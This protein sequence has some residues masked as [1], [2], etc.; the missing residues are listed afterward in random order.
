MI[1]F[2]SFAPVVL[3]LSLGSCTALWDRLPGEANFVDWNQSEDWGGEEL[4]EVQLGLKAGQLEVR[5]GTSSELYNLKIHY[6]ELA[7]EPQ[8]ELQRQGNRAELFIGMEGKGK[9]LRGLGDSRLNLCLNPDVP[10]EL[11]AR[12]G[13]GGSNIDLSGMK[14]HS[15]VLQSGVGETKVGISEPNRARCKE[16]ELLSGVGAFEVVGLGHLA[17]DELEFHGGIGKA[18]LDF[19]G[20]CSQLGEITIRVGIGDV[21]IRLPRSIGAEVRGSEGF[22]SEFNMPGFRRC[23]DAYHSENSDHAA[24]IVRFQIQAGI[25]RI[26][27][28]WI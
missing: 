5:P 6:N 16:V 20:S 28:E 13:V 14:I 1:M 9:S 3:V 23:G 2:S 11:H 18:K 8:V 12:T 25:G 24:E 7:F 17:F 21:E 15:L 26:A 19:S 22:L 4:L 27:L 10:L